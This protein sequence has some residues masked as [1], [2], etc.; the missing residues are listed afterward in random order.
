MSRGN[1]ILYLL[2]NDTEMMVWNQTFIFCNT[3]KFAKYINKHKLRSILEY[4]KHVSKCNNHFT[5]HE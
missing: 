5:R 3:A 4:S 1:G 2:Q